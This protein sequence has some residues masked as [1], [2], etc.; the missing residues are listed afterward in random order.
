[1]AFTIFKWSLF[2]FSKKM[3]HWNFEILGYFVIGAGCWIEKDLELSHSLPNCSKDSWKLLPLF[4]SINWPSLVIYRD[5]VWKIYSKMC[6]VSFTNILHDVIDLVNRGMVK[7]TRTWI[8]W[9]WNITFLQNKKILNLCL[10]WHILNGYRFIA[11]VTF[12]AEVNIQIPKYIDFIVIC[13]KFTKMGVY[14]F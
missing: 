6:P 7:K 1:M 8:S 13:I 12:K 3:K 10:R 4:R 14:N 9:E 11:E 5:A 2:T